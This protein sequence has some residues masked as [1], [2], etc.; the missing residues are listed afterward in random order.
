MGLTVH[1]DDSSLIRSTK[2]A[3]PLIVGTNFGT[4]FASRQGF[5]EH[6]LLRPP[7]LP[8][9]P[10]EEHGEILGTVFPIMCGESATRDTKERHMIV[11]VIEGSKVPYMSNRCFIALRILP[12]EN[13]SDV[14]RAAALC[15]EVVL[16]RIIFQVSQVGRA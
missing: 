4:N 16:G 10:E 6:S 12:I 15:Q 8:V 1:H 5:A 14:S 3:T 2:N 9:Q 11:Y 13:A 7:L